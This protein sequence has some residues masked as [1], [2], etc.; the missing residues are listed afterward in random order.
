[1]DYYCVNN[2]K[3]IIGGPIRISKCEVKIL[4][5]TLSFFSAVSSLLWNDCHKEGD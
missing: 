4:L 2:G 3:K 5:C 1:M